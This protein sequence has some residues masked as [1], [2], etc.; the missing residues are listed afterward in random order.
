MD[1][2]QLNSQLRY[3]LSMHA[4]TNSEKFGHLN[5]LHLIE[6]HN[7]TVYMESK[8]YACMPAVFHVIK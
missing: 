1:H 7:W 2:A 4:L 8:L 5:D 3:F 6:N